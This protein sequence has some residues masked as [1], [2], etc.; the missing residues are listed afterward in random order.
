LHLSVFLYGALY[1]TAPEIDFEIELP[2]EIE[3]GLTDEAVVAT[4]APTAADSLP[5]TTPET[6]DE[7]VEDGDTESAAADA[8]AEMAAADA[9]VADTGPEALAQA[10]T[11]PP[12]TEDGEGVGGE[13][14]EG[15]TRLP[16]G[17]Q[18]AL[19]LDMARIRASTLAPQVRRLLT[20]IPDWR[21]VLEGSEIDPIDD[22][23]RVLIASPNLQRSRMLLAGRYEVDRVDVN[24]VVARMAAARGA[25]APWTTSDGV[26][27]APWA[28][29][30]DTARVLA[31]VGPRH[32]TITRP[33]DLPRILAVARVRAEEEAAEAAEES[34]EPEPTGAD[35]LL[36]MEEG[37]AL[38]VEVEGARNFVRGMTRGV[39]TR[40]R[41]SAEEGPDGSVRLRAWGEFETPEAASE[42]R[43]YWERLRDR[44]ARNALVA[45]LGFASPLRS[46]ELVADDTELRAEA[47]LGPRQIRTILD[48]LRGELEARDRRLR[49]RSQPTPVAP[50]PAMGMSGRLDAPRPAPS[51]M[52]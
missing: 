8:G 14:D 44:A 9:G 24:A 43:G 46:T 27:V 31:K 40:L 20:A 32:F 26:P 23:D 18:I 33:E 25:E 22:L 13:A 35:A 48:Y 47:S 30:D 49:R 52:R 29:A 15:E 11:G 28:N 7:L 2:N 37:E 34:E 42:A 45:M 19:R 1:L 21:A 51:P 50:E 39:P 17:A 38:S 36:S 3:F 12:G 6:S 41:L 5:E 4:S 16:A 10:D